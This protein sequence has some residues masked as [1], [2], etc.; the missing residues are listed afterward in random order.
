MWHQ[1]NSMEMALQ[2]V[3]SN[4]ALLD[5]GG[6]SNSAQV[7]DVLKRKARYLNVGELDFTV[8]EKKSSVYYYSSKQAY[9]GRKYLTVMVDCS[10]VESEPVIPIVQ[11]KAIHRLMFFSARLPDFREGSEGIVIIPDNVEFVS[12][13][14]AVARQF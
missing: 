2:D 6:C 14:N 10:G 3:S 11:M 7:V 13:K 9:K 4:L 5:G 8:E 12:S 1:Y